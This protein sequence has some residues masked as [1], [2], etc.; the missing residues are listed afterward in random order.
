MKRL[1]KIL[2]YIF[3][4]PLLAILNFFYCGGLGFLE[5][6]QDTKNEIQKLKSNI[7]ND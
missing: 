7:K 6:I 5:S 4:C 1:V 2:S 3:I